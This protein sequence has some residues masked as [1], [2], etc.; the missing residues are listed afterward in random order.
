[1]LG[2]SQYPYLPMLSPVF[3]R[4]EEESGRLSTKKKFF[5]HKKQV[6]TDVFTNC[7]MTFT[8]FW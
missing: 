8:L 3:M 4:E 2:T 5:F 6:K 1:M 7:G